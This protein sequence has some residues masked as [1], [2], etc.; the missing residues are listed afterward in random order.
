MIIKKI[1]IENFGK[2]SGQFYTFKPGFNLIFGNNEDGKTTLMSF[3]KLMFYG[4]SSGKS[5]DIA[6]NIRKKYTPWNGA[7]MSGAIEFEINGEEFRLH[8]EFKR[9]AS[10][11]K[12][13]VT[14]LTTGEKC[15]IPNA[16]DAGQYFFNMNQGEFERS[17]FVENYGG[18][19]SDASSDSLAMKIANLSASGDENISDTEVFSRLSAAKEELISKSGKKGILVDEQANLEKLRYNLEVLIAHNNGQQQLFSD[20]NKLKKEITEAEAGIENYNLF[21]KLETAKK[22]IIIF[23]ELT[24]K[25]KTQKDISEEL[26][27]FG[28]QPE[29]LFELLREGKQLKAQL[30]ANY[31][32]DEPKPADVISDAEY[33]S[34]IEAEKRLSELDEDFGF[35]NQSIRQ[36]EEVLNRRISH[37]TKKRRIL[38]VITAGT[39]AVIAAATAMLFPSHFWIGIPILLLGLGSAFIFCHNAKKK[40]LNS[41]SV[42]LAKQD[43]EN[44]VRHLS[45]YHDGLFE[46]SADDILG[47]CRVMHHN[48]ATEILQKINHYGCTSSEE[49]QLKTQRAQ[50]TKFATIT[51]TLNALKLRFIQLVSKAKPVESF[52]KANIV[53]EEIEVLVSNHQKTEHDIEILS[54]TIVNGKISAEYAYSQLKSLSDFVADTQIDKDSLVENPDELNFMLK[55]KRH[56][57][58]ELQSK[59]NIPETGESQLL[60][61]INDVTENLNFL[62]DRYKSLSI[63]STVL[64]QAVSEMNKGLGSHLSTKTG[65][66]LNLM[67][68]G[69]YSDVLVARDLS[70]ETRS[71]ATENYREWKY[72]SSGAVDRVYLALRLAATDI[73]AETH[74]TLPLFLD[75]ILTQYDDENCKSTLKFLDRY[76]K[77]SGSVSQL[78][79]FTCHNHIAQMAKDII[80]DTTEIKL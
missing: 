48:L 34:I 67:S 26:A 18:F 52:E 30:E 78:F 23:S 25:F 64:E 44:K 40:A 38:S 72:L 1:E 80:S 61:Q 8:K 16:A 19:S 79:F 69:K 68:G 12:V 60:S 56:E 57:L 51:S 59:I 32:S 24:E 54:K 66:Y 39:S 31:Y 3:I 58:G 21:R 45:F 50:N 20:I 28:L 6:K 49:L 74:N 5:S 41:L 36:S 70:V 76:Q 9:I 35:I 37:G 42:Q 75:D 47:E 71:T 27:S 7:P 46:K 62:T 43:F 10:G 15:A 29:E 11:D 13:T 17:V 63:A 14:N 77:E 65:E 2:F 22:N 55:Q 4:N 33:Q 53:F 73:M